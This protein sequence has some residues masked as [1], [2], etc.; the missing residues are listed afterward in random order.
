MCPV[1]VFAK[2]NTCK[3]GQANEIMLALGTIC[4]CINTLQKPI[5]VML[6]FVCSSFVP[7]SSSDSQVST[8]I[9]MIKPSGV[10]S[11]KSSTFIVLKFTTKINIPLR[12]MLIIYSDNMT[13]CSWG[14]KTR[15]QHMFPINSNVMSSL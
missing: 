5:L 12:Y 4:I 14:K 9:E 8:R 1:Y 6:G 11:Y 10:A 3:I 2:K 13:K 15:S 7:K